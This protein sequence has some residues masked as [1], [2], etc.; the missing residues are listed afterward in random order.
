MITLASAALWGLHVVLLSRWSVP[1]HTFRL[2]RTQTATVTAMAMLGV[3]IKAV[4]TGGSPLPALPPNGNAWLSVL[5]LAV[6]ASAAAMALLSWSQSRVDATRAAVI[7]T[8]EPAVAGLTAVLAGTQLTARTVTGA[9]F[10]IAAMSSLSSAADPPRALADE[11]LQEVDQAFCKPPQPQ[12]WQ[13]VARPGTVESTRSSE[14]SLTDQ[15][16]EMGDSSLG[17]GSAFHQRKRKES[18]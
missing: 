1:G 13:P 8:L 17:R 10:L 18:R 9:V 4:V 11:E 2:A 7:L 3:L 14:P 16:R 5:F 15:G 12:F 6:L